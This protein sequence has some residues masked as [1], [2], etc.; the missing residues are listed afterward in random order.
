MTRWVSVEVMVARNTDVEI[1]IHK[2]NA[3]LATAADC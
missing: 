3:A 2:K 1:P